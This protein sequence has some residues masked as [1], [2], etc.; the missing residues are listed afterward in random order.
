MAWQ[1]QDVKHMHGEVI[2][3]IIRGCE[4][5]LVQLAG[6]RTDNDGIFESAFKGT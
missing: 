3:D 4:N 1:W 6:T 2:H 5:D